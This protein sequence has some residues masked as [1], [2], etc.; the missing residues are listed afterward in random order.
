MS[1]L[2]TPR[3]TNTRPSLARPG[4]NT[5]STP[6]LRPSNKTTFDRKA[7]LNALAVP[8][9]RSPDMSGPANLGGDGQPLTVG[10]IVDVPGQM[11][12][13][14]KFIGAVKAKNGT[15]VGVELSKEFA[16]RGKNDG[17]VDG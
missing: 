15:F 7:S 12:G 11:H 10:D 8:P 13:T 6:V 17:N 4:I 2:Q 3:R 14:V 5:A 9:L 1:T 16:S